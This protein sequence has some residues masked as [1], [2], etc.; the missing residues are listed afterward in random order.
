MM[1]QGA[2]AKAV[3]L[4]SVVMLRE[5]TATWGAYR[6][7]PAGTFQTPCSGD[8]WKPSASETLVPM[9]TSSTFSFCRQQENT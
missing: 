6:T 8:I 2:H 7:A 4:L 1:W 5:D 3:L 9:V